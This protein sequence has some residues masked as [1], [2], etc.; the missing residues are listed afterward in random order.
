M[1]SRNMRVSDAE[2]AEVADR[3]AANFADGRLDQEEY[4]ERVA[5]AMSAKTQADFDGLFDDLPGM[6]APTDNRETRSTAA[7]GTPG[8]A[9]PRSG[10]R[11]GPLRLVLTVVLILVALSVVSHIVT[12]A[13]WFFGWFFSPWWIL[14]LV[15]L[16]ILLARHHR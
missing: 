15:A 11:R 8:L 5:R 13:F 7:S 16:I 2:R 12:S 3:L 1:S 9:G 4:D 14:A 6:G 10:R